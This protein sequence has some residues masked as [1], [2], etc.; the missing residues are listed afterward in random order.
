MITYKTAIIVMIVLLV[1]S[2]VWMFA[3]SGEKKIFTGKMVG[4]AL[5]TVVISTLFGAAALLY[6]EPLDWLSITGLFCLLLLLFSLFAWWYW[7]K[8]KLLDLDESAI[9]RWEFP[10]AFSIWALATL[11][12][13]CALW[14]RQA[15]YGSGGAD[16]GAM[17][18]VAPAS[19]I[20]LLPMVVAYVH[21]LWNLIPIVIKYREPW[22]LPVNQDASVIEPSADALRIFF[23]I[24]INEATTEAISFDVSVPRRVCLGQVF[25]HLL[26]QHNVQKRAARRIEVAYENKTDY[27]YGWLLYRNGKRW[28]WNYRDYLDMDSPVRHS[29]LIN[30]ERIYAERVR[31][32]ETKNKPL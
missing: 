25:H 9:F 11:V 8:Q 12:L 6:K 29:D 27:L 31:V 18:V 17:M 24:P 16:A 13:F 20:L 7:H 26:Y 32:W 21:R 4:L 3:T 28:W 5:K 1:A 14:A 2:I 19:L 15:R 30:G 22:R 10:Q 23:E